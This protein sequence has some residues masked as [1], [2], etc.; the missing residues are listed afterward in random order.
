MP[1][2]FT[3][4]EMLVVVAVII[5]LLSIVSPMTEHTFKLAQK[6]TCQ[7]H[8]KEIAT[9]AQCYQVEHNG[10]GAKRKKFCSIFPERY[11]GTE[12]M[13]YCPTEVEMANAAPNG[14]RL[15]YGMNHYGRAFNDNKKYFS[16]FD[17]IRVSYVMVTDVVYFADSECDQSPH[18]IG[19]GSRNKGL[20]DEY[21]PLYWSFQRYAHK[22]HL[23]GY[24]T[25]KLDGSAQWY[26]GLVKNFEAWWV[27]KQ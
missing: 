7:T 9:A 11:L 1:Q 3:I 17:G 15:D 26:P 19:A 12:E 2:A 13:L 10:W 16:T 23:G 18:D 20:G 4:I 6:V 22:R 14:K 8:L 21:W 5:L 24:N 27:R 25:G